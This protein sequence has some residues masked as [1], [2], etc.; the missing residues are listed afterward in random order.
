MEFLRT[1]RLAPFIMC[2]A[3]V[4]LTAC[5]GQVDPGGS[6][7]P[8]GSSTAS[9]D[10]KA[11]SSPHASDA[12]DGR[13]FLSTSVTGHQLVDG[14]QVRLSFR[15]GSLNANAGCNSMFGAY[16]VEQD[17]LR[18]SDLAGTQMG[19]DPELMAQDE[20]LAIFLTAGPE[21]AVQ[22]DELRLTS[23]D[24]ELVL[25]DREVADPDRPLQGTTWQL[26][27]HRTSDTVAHS[28]GMEQATL[29][30]DGNGR[31]QVQTGCNTGSATY[32]VSGD[33]LEIGAL[34]LTKMS[35][36]QPAREIEQLIVAAIDQQT[37]HFT[38]EANRLSLEGDHEGIDLLAVATS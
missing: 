36:P 18:V 16:A 32:E 7:E 14:T 23:G 19:C 29:L 33:T 1:L 30:F 9:A 28:T 3:A 25:T 22:A 15:D 20:W 8:A 24:T 5:G 21:L 35:C 2:A 31:L 17:T 13:T 37:L 11:D 27:S 4:V 10:D 38:V 12:V 6:T 26:D 34:A